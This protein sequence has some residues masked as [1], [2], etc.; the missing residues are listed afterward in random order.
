MLRIEEVCHAKGKSIYSNRVFSLSCALDVHQV[1]LLGR[2]E[3]KSCIPPF[4]RL[5][6][7]VM[8][9]APYKEARSVFWTVDNGSGYCGPKEVAKPFEWKFTYKDLDRLISKIRTPR[10]D[11]YQLAA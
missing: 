2:Y 5:V 1:K 7:P 11:W 6:D 10:A 4:Y 3:R 9:Q 8:T